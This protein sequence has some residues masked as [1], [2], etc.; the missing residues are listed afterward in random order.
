MSDSRQ[1]ESVEGQLVEA[2]EV[3]RAALAEREM[4]ELAHR[5]ADAPSDAEGWF[6]LLSGYP[7]HAE[8]FAA[9]ARMKGALQAGGA[10]KG[11]PTVEQYAVLQ[12]LTVALPRVNDL[13]LAAS[14]K[15]KIAE[16]AVQAA[17]PNLLWR[18]NFAAARPPFMAPM[19]ALA[20][21]RQF[22]AGELLFAFH[23]H[24]SYVWP[25]RFPPR[26]IPGFLCEMTF[27]MKGWG[28]MI[29]PHINRWRPNP[30]IVQQAEVERSL[31]RMAKTLQ[32]RPDVRFLM[33]DSWFL[34]AQVA[35]FAPHMAWWRTV[36][37]G[38][39][40]YIVDMEPA[41]EDSG[42]MENSRRRTELHETGS[43]HPRRTLA[44]WSRDDM[45]A[46]S[47]Q[48]MDLADDGEAAP[49]APAAPPRRLR[50]KSPAPARP[51]KH[52]SPL[53][54]WDGLTLLSRNPKKYA[55]VVLLLPA[56]AAAAVAAGAIALWAAIPAFFVTFIAA[57]VL[58]YY[59]FQ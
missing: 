14:V 45:I 25:L 47:R 55:L 8:S 46:W 2:L 17:R 9:I 33:G 51:A 54:L 59:L 43:F 22:P 24:L 31:W 13:A 16:L 1:Q 52:N 29:S 11:Q 40:A 34:S 26:A 5:L 48:R 32:Y 3:C 15:Q 19:A 36:F 37:A 21:L 38:G 23:S 44:L 58:Q 42:F 39:G 28:A 41:A 10:T 53:H 6:R 49:E 12:S 4:N 50:M 56:L 18:R 30:L 27:G 57:W 20:T 35:D 7:D